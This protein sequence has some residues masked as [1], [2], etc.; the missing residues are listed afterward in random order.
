VIS[1][2][3]GTQGVLDDI[4]VSGV[5]AFESAMLAHVRHEFPEILQEM[6]KTGDLPEAL[7]KKLLDVL[8][9]FR[10]QYVATNLAGAA[11]RPA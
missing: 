11:K 6:E 3:A 4:P 7:A 9:N 1:I 10:G 8:H 5:L 2:F